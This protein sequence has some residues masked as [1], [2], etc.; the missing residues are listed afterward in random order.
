VRLDDWRQVLRD[1]GK[2]AG[3]AADEGLRAIAANDG[4]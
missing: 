3:V 1:A 2:L 4:R